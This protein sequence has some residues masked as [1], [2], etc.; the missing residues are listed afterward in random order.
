VAAFLAYFTVA[1]ESP[2]WVDGLERP[3][4]TAPWLAR[5]VFGTDKEWA[6]WSWFCLDLLWFWGGI[7]LAVFVGSLVGRRS[8]ASSLPK[9][10]ITIA[11]IAIMLSATYLTQRVI[12]E[13]VALGLEA[14]IGFKHEVVLDS[15]QVGEY[16]PFVTVHKWDEFTEREQEIYIQALLE[17]WS[18]TLYGHSGTKE[19][20]PPTEFS[21][22]TACV[23]G[24]KVSSF[25]RLPD[26]GYFLGEVDKPVV[27]HV[28]NQTPIICKN[29][30]DK[31]DGSW[32]P[33][34]IISKKDWDSFSDKEKK[35]YLTGYIDL[36]Y[37]FT[38]RM[39]AG[40]SST[41]KHKSDQEV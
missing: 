6:G 16:L 35:I 5:L 39:I 18:F 36:A 21:A 10:L 22:F 25:R 34:S 15:T 41:E 23:E 4:H 30:I 19:K 29:Y 28:F 37:F 13:G 17:T 26:I 27:D 40:I 11:G 32:R 7:S 1:K 20:Q 8:V 12:K 33:V 2:Y 3:L 31:G 14:G 24:E 38:V 9:P